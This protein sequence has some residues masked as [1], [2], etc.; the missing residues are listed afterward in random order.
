M[1]IAYYQQRAKAYIPQVEQA[2]RFVLND[3]AIPEALRES[4]AYSVFA[5]GNF[6][7]RQGF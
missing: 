2:L 3:A 7:A 1:C 4:M 6:N 5:G